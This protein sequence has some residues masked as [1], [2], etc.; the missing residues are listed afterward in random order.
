MGMS[1]GIHIEIRAAWVDSSDGGSAP[2]AVRV[3]TSHRGLAG[4]KGDTFRTTHEAPGREDRGKI[5]V[6]TLARSPG[7]DDALSLR[8]VERDSEDIKGTGRE[9]R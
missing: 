1:T 5:G 3:A 6:T 8:G 9:Q 4:G 2:R 7:S